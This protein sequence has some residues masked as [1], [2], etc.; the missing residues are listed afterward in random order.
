MADI[1]RADLH[2]GQQ[3]CKRWPPVQVDRRC[4]GETAQVNREACPNQNVRSG[5]Q[6]YQ[7]LLGKYIRFLVILPVL[8]CVPAHIRTTAIVLSRHAPISNC[9][10]PESKSRTWET[11][12]PK[13]QRYRF[14]WGTKNV[15]N[16][17]A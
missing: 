2:G 6:A 16:R 7:S 12:D 3:V 9:L 8:L 1:K 5:P 10:P 4:N 14:T 13:D 17:P 11:F 15:A